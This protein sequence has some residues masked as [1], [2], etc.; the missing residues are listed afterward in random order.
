VHTDLKKLEGT[1]ISS[2]FVLGLPTQ[3]IVNMSME[4]D[5]LPYDDDSTTPVSIGPGFPVAFMDR[6]FKQSVELITLNY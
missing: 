3:K 4:L 5:D 6:I 2:E 1:L